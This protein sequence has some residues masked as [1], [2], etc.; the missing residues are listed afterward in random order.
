MARLTVEKALL[1]IILLLYLI[2]G[3]LFA[4]QTP[5]WQA[6][7]E[8]A[9]YNYI[10]QVASEGCCPVIEPGDWNQS[11]LSELT[12]ERFHPSL[13]ADLDTIQYEDHQPPLY[14][15]LA[16]IIWKLTN[17]G[18]IALRLFGVLLGTIVVYSAYEIGKTILPERPGVA[19]GAAVF[20]AFLPQHMAM[21]ASVKQRCTGG[22]Y[23]RA[24]TVGQPSVS[25]RGRYSHMALGNVV[26]HRLYDQDNDLFSRRDCAAGDYPALVGDT[27]SRS[28]AQH[29][30]SGKD[31][32]MVSDSCLVIRWHLVGAQPRDIWRAGFSGLAGA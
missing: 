32:D 15:L 2:V 26:G 19:L 6:P 1:G 10:A 20:V 21:L 13:L 24:G 29:D 14:Y 4:T 28:Q 9:H 7:D 18:L 8:P 12:S 30:T 11:Y 25:E 31:A 5:A 3:T 16:S 17:G 23:H 22:G 27:Q